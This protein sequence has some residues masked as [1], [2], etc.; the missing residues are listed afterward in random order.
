MIFHLIS[1]IRKDRNNS[2]GGLLIYFKDDTFVERAT[3]LGNDTDETIRIKVK[4][5]GH[6]FD[7]CNMYRPEWT[8]NEYWTRL[9]HAIGI[10]YQV[11]DNIVILGDLKFVLFI[12]NNN[13]LIDTMIC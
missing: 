1:F 4:A 8:D 7:L 6:A 9:N 2:G 5:R 3:A 13:T 12:A 10:G 11:N